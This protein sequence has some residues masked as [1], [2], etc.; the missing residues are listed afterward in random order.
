MDH[1]RGWGG[2]LAAMLGKGERV[3]L[4]ASTHFPH[5]QGAESGLFFFLSLGSF[6]IFP[7]STFRIRLENSQVSILLQIHPF[8]LTQT[9]QTPGL[10]KSS[11][12]AS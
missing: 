7:T 11:A 6:S 2:G 3:K 5:T 4:V 8:S 12:E 10:E 1:R 9:S